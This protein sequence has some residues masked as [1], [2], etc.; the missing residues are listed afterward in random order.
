MLPSQGGNN[1]KFLTTN[2]ASTSWGS[3]V[4]SVGLALPAELTV[5]NSPV[6]TT[7]TLTATWASQ[8]ANTIFASP[9][10]AAGTPSF[11][12]MTAN[13]VPNLDASKITTGNL[14]V[15]RGGTGV[16]SFTGNGVI[17][18]NAA[19]TALTSQ[20]LTN[21][22][23]LVGSTG[24]APVAATLTA[25]NGISIVNAAGLITISSNA[26]GSNKARV[27]LLVSAVSYTANAAPAGFTLSATSV[28]NITILEA[29]GYP[30]TATVTNINTVNNTFDFVISGYP[31][32]GS[33]ALVTL[34]N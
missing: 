34:Q 21:G 8:S 14:G 4:T 24:A 9:D 30:I 17:V 23:I 26:N 20:T 25:G 1:G 16:T 3:A 10:G 28:I 19:G 12:L 27:N 15:S 13:D 6:T 5:S 2:G 31:T 29:G 33:T 32:A 22:Q 18:A 7:G 11:R